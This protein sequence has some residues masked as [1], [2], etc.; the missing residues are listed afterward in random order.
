M[1]RKSSKASSK[2]SAKSFLAKKSAKLTELS[3]AGLDILKPVFWIRN[4]LDP[5]P[6]ICTTGLKILLF[7]QWLLKCQQKLKKVVFAY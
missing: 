1:A 4:F 7:S 5:D 2:K 3:R 6:C